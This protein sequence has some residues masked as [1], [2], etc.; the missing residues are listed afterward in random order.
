MPNYGELNK[1]LSALRAHDNSAAPFRFDMN[2]AVYESEAGTFQG[3]M[4]LVWLHYMGGLSPRQVWLSLET[5]DDIF[6]Q[7]GAHF[8]LTMD[9][10]ESLLYP[11]FIF[12]E[13]P[14]EIQLGHIRAIDAAH[15]LERFI[16]TLIRHNGS[17]QAL[18]SWEWYEHEHAS[19]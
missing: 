9:Q 12:R 3:D 17:P 10:V 13:H 1:L 2:Y 15:T 19:R 16:A 5:V 18:A 14:A 6:E 8:G 7:F 11:S 4:C